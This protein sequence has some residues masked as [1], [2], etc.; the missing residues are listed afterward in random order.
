MTDS[1]VRYSPEVEVPVED[2]A[3]LIAEI[4]D[5]MSETNLEAF[6][7]HRHAIRDA[8]AKSHGVLTGTL[9]IPADLP[10][11]LRQGVFAQPGEYDVVARISSAPGDIH[12][13]E[14]PQPRGFAVA[15]DERQVVV[16]GEGSGAVALYALSEDG[17]LTPED[18]RDTGAGANWVR[19]A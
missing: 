4:T 16:A 7:R 6:E 19:F 18:R 14:I 12:S 8:H 10:A 13:D 2:E 17:E 15:P 5:Q 3:R 9:T 1:Y 11:H